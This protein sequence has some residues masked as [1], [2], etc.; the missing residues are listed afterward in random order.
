MDKSEFYYLFV[1]T[2]CLAELALRLSDDDI[3]KIADDV[4]A[5]SLSDEDL[6]AVVADGFEGLDMDA[7]DGMAFFGDETEA[8]ISETSELSGSAPE[9]AN[10]ESEEFNI[11][12]YMEN[13]YSHEAYLQERIDRTFAKVD[14]DRLKALVS[15]IKTALQPITA[16]Q[17]GPDIEKWLDLYKSE[18]VDL[19][20]IVVSIRQADD[21]N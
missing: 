4:E 8:D 12:R 6:Q 16:R 19:S 1:N 5:P 21:P 10:L 13:A 9:S 17:T 7:L 14:L 18:H 20:E 3:A 2:N 15:R 11:N